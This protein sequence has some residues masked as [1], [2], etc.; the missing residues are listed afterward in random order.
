MAQ[1]IQPGAGRKEK[2]VLYYDPDCGFC[3][4]TARALE[5]LTFGKVRSEPY[6]SPEADEILVGVKPEERYDRA[7]MKWDEQILGG[8]EAMWHSLYL[9]PFGFILRPLRFL[10]WFHPISRRFYRFVAEHRSPKC[11]LKQHT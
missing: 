2:A 5:K 8:H 4:K 6:T 3:T 7:W 9:L 10:P 11:R 1:Q